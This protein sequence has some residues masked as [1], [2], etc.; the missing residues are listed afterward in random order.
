MDRRSFINNIARASIITG[1]GIMTTTLLFKKAKTTDCD[2]QFVCSK[3]RN[4]SVCKLPEASKFK[5]INSLN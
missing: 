2:F 3:C 1:I 4:L 5:E